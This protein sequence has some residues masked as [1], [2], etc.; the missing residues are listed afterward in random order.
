M[1]AVTAEEIR[2]MLTAEGA[3][4]VGFAPVERFAGAPVGHRPED[5]L[6]TAKSV[7]A[8]AV[9]VPKGVVD[10]EDYL[11][12]AEDFPQDLRLEI[13]HNN[14][15]GRLGYSTLNMILDKMTIRLLWQL[16]G[17]GYQA[18]G[19]PATYNE[20]H[21]AQSDSKRSGYRGPFSH[22]HA[23]VAAGL[24]EF[25]LNNI[26]VTEEYGPWVRLGSLIT[27]LALPPSPLVDKPICLRDG[28]RLCLEG[29]VALRVVEEELDQVFLESPSRTDP[30]RCR[31]EPGCLTRGSCLRS[32]PL[33]Q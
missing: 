9:R 25:G 7:I 19:F 26:L 12:R 27:D 14:V 18:V 1:E 23:A 2:A 31:E 3:V 6:P 17:S 16:E 32:C 10:Y 5:F 20:Y 8:W 21:G 29:C 33:G 28:C 13:L 4:K 11:V 15:Y 22:R 30:R 24:G